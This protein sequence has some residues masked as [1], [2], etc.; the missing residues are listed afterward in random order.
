M[1]RVNL[2]TARIVI[3][4]A[5]AAGGIAVLANGFATGAVVPPA[6]GGGGSE[7]TSPSDASPTNSPSQPPKET[8]SPQIEGVRIA[9]F[10]GTNETGLAAEVQQILEADGYVAAQDP[11]DADPKPVP[12]TIVYFRG[13]V[14][15]AQNRSNARYIADTYFDGARVALLDPDLAVNIADDAQAIIIVGVDYVGAPAGSTGGG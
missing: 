6:G 3:I 10:N 1:G 11:A 8:P 5:L 7:T 13:G 4:L 2:G 9:V 12:K 15:A 14:D